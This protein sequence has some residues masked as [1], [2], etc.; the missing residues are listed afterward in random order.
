MAWSGAEPMG[1]MGFGSLVMPCTWWPRVG[2]VSS[3][4]PTCTAA[5]ISTVDTVDIVG[6]FTSIT[7]GAYANPIIRHFDVNS[8]IDALKVAKRTRTSLTSNTWES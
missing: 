3:A 7:I 5:T 8:N 1:V 2:G 6:K 4:N